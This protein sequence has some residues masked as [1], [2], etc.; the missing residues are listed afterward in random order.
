MAEDSVIK[1][2][3]SEFKLWG[4]KFQHQRSN[5]GHIE[6]AWQASPDKPVRKTYL[7]H[8]GSDWRGWL[9]QRA[10]VRRLFQQDGLS[11]KKP[12]KPEPLLHK[13]LSVPKEPPEKPEDQFKA[14]R[15][16]IADLTNFV[17]ELGTIVS[18]LVDKLTPQAPQPAE[19]PAPIPIFLPPALP[20][21]RAPSTRSK[22]AIDY[23]SLN[24]N[25]LDAIARDMELEPFLVKRKL[26]YLAK[27]GKVEL[28]DGRW[29]KTPPPK[30]PKTK[31]IAPVIAAR[32]QKR[33][34]HAVNGHRH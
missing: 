2:I 33:N 19:M 13:A 16:E 24:W 28:S 12:E 23:L 22:K 3:S 9:N 20:L 4:V 25:S 10:Q 30:K 29:R 34:G 1:L 18:T 14:M 32:K 6:L 27:L 21:K 17:L 11:L 26:V 5:G 15:A 31:K 8:T 7:A